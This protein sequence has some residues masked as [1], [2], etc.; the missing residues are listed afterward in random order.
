MNEITIVVKS[1]NE[2]KPGM[3]QAG[4]DVDKLEGKA[5]GLGD[6]F[7]RTSQ[8]SDELARSLRGTSGKAD[9]TVGIF[10]RLEAHS[11]RLRQEFDRTNSSGKG[12]LGNLLG[13]NTAERD[14]EKIGS[15][16]TRTIGDAGK[17]GGKEM[18]KNIS[19]SVQ[20]AESTPGLGP[21]LV[22]ILVGAAV[23][24]SPMMGAAISGG[25]LAGVGLAGIGLGIAGQIK[26]PAVHKAFAEL[27]YDLEGE[28][29]AA[30]EP[31][32]G[33]LIGSIHTVGDAL[34]R[35][36]AGIDFKSLAGELPELSGGLAGLIDKMG[37]GLSE[38]FKAS[39]PALHE[40]STDLPA[41]GQALGNFFH[42]LADSKGSVEGLRTLLMLLV[43][44][45][46]VTGHV[47]GG[48]SNAYDWILRFGDGASAA[49]SKWADF[50]A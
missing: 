24:A 4:S 50:L 45:I 9:E 36:L 16:L 12:V 49:G 47:V 27:G 39:L 7:G 32:R 48:L 22:G 28:L 15:G 34:H 11:A 46:D 43:G 23:A 1:R 30:T 44:F 37:P 21:I 33:P 35:A 5:R 40:L 8:H 14:L 31:L 42:E 20:G 17:T 6:E 25:L 18:A 3:D 41:V 29:A 13:G 19:A 26:D 10:D 38:A 2:T